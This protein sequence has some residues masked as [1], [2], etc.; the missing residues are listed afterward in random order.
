MHIQRKGSI[1]Y[2]LGFTAGV[3][4]LG[5]ILFSS[6]LTPVT[7]APYGQQ[8]GA[9][10]QTPTPE[11]AAFF[12]QNIQPILTDHCLDCHSTATRSAGGLPPG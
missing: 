6:L 7:A 8:A 10:E 4:V 3:L 11:Q 9:Q 2:F 1:P 12:Q 5:G